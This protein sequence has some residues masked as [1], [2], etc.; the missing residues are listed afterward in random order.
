MLS[1]DLLETFYSISLLHFPPLA[2]LILSYPY[3]LGLLLVSPP[4]ESKPHEVRGF[5]VFC[6]TVYSQNLEQCLEH[7]YLLKLAPR[8]G[9]PF[10]SGLSSAHIPA[11]HSHLI[12]R[13]P[14][15]GRLAQ[16][17][18]GITTVTTHSHGG[19]LL[20]HHSWQHGWEQVTT[21]SSGLGR[22]GGERVYDTQ[23]I[24]VALVLSPGRKWT[25]WQSWL[26]SHPALPP[27]L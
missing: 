13:D 17:T 11:Y 7:K 23:M 8:W 27:M 14:Q 25:T 6:L 19:A 16:S 20:F 5:C 26:S 10:F 1:L 18:E 4:V 12:W 21:P 2:L 24:L 9:D 22:T 3:L 15:G